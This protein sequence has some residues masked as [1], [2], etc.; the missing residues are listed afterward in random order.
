ML[1]AITPQVSHQFAGVA[2]LL[3]ATNKCLAQSNKSR[4]RA[5]ATKKQNQ[6]GVGRARL[7]WSSVSKADEAQGAVRSGGPVGTL[8]GSYLKEREMSQ[9]INEFRFNQEMK[10][11]RGN[12]I[13]VGIA[14]AIL[15]VVSWTVIVV[16]MGSSSSSYS[17]SLATA[18]RASITLTNLRH[19]TDN[20]H[21]R[22][23]WR[24]KAIVNNPTNVSYRN[25][26]WYCT[27]YDN[28]EP[29]TEVP[30]MV[31]SVEPNFRTATDGAAEMTGYREVTSWRCR[32]VSSWVDDRA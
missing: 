14:L 8:T 25:I 7:R 18:E 31:L 22:N 28:N 15:L 16:E 32:Y 2:H 19:A 23:W 26:T 13:G 1:S 21:M 11:K 9:T 24:F 17:P 10:N 30:V 12:L 29:L 6:T 27:F 5:R 20:P 4:T 3:A